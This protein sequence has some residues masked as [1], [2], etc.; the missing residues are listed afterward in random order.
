VFILADDIGYGDLSCYGAK[1][2]QTPNIDK[3]AAQG[4]RFTDVHTPAST[5]TP[6]RYGLMTG[7]Y[8]FR[9]KKG[10]AI[11]AGDAVLSIRPGSQTL[12][13]TFQRAGYTTGIVG[14]WHLGLGE[15]DGIDWNGDI[16]PGPMEVGFDYAFYFPATG[17]RVPCVYIEGRHIA[18]LDPKDPIKVS[19]KYKV[20]DEPTGHDHPELLTLKPTHGHDQTIVNGISRIGWMSGGHAA[21]WVDEHM[22]DNLVKRG[23]SFIETNQDKPFFLYFATHNIHVPRVPAPRFRGKSQ[24][25][26]RGDAI[27]EL[28]AAVG[29]LMA[30]LDRLKLTDK[31]VVI[32]TSDN[33][34]IMDDGYED[35]GNFDHP[36]NGILR[37]HKGTLFEGGNRVPFISRWP[38]VISEKTESSDMFCLI[39]MEATFAGLLGQKLDAD[40]APDS[41]NALDAVL[42]RPHDKPVRE[43]MVM[44]NGGT[45][46]PFA[47]RDGNWKL[48]QHAKANA[49]AGNKAAKPNS[50][51]SNVLA[52]MKGIAPGPLLFD[53]SKDVTESD[54]VAATHPEKVA[55]LTAL[56]AKIREEGHTRPGL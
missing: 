8:A 16:K 3:L 11:L 9:N 54:N 21:C 29:E 44:M 39:D 50:P 53:L 52:G 5:C 24:C 47:I 38:G 18:G 35:V 46:G 25:G 27:V 14:K 6:T 31:T 2:V 56:L 48:I 36:C 22:C 10:S 45:E 26:N 55:E 51:N 49:G 15:K 12:P 43:S 17:D 7:Q 4:R 42:G 19:Y 13:A 23:V 1:L 33:G 41:F 37:G 30:T 32:F 28:D 40:A 20:G 34:G